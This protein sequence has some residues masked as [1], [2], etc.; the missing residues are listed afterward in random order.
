MHESCIQSG[1]VTQEGDPAAHE[2][3]LCHPAI[4]FQETEVLPAGWEIKPIQPHAETRLREGT[5]DA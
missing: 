5:T 3:A 1:A 2:V 4:N